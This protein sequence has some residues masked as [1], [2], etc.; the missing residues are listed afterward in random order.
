LARDVLRNVGIDIDAAENGVFLPTV[1][2]GA[3][4]VHNGGHTNAYYD[5]VNS[6]LAKF[7]SAGP[8]D[9][10]QVINALAA[11][12]NDLEKGLLKIGR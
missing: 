9:K 6:A 2:S 3:K 5:A 1:A 10:Q 7:A 12:R 11:L 4:A 8:A